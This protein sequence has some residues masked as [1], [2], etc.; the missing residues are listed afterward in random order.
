MRRHPNK[1]HKVTFLDF[2]GV[3]LESSSIKGDTFAELF[4]G[5][6]TD[7]TQ[8]VKQLHREHYGLNRYGKL[9]K[10]YTEILKKPITD[11][12]CDKHAHE[13]STLL[14][15]K[16]SKCPL[17]KG[18]KEYLELTAAHNH[19]VYVLSAAPLKEIYEII[20]MRG[21]NKYFQ[22]IH[23]YPEDKADAGIKIIRE[24]GYQAED[25]CMI[26]DGIE[27]LIAARKMCVDFIGRVRESDT[28]RFPDEISIIKDFSE[29][30]N[31]IDPT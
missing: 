16:L 27:D 13:F 14:K 26:G 9:R 2:D 25:I 18:M 17:V 30:E 28:N 23:G 7:V 5:Y 12:Q 21:I 19:P 4:I 11:T 24:K 6:G 29:F 22:G 31:P 15:D 3:I 10:I 1:Q 8:K 20:E